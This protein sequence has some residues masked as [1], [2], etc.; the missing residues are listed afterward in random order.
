VSSSITL[1][2]GAA[3]GIGRAVAIQ[4]AN[5]GE[6]VFGIDIDEFGLEE[7]SQRS[8]GKIEIFNCDISSPT[9]VKALFES[10]D[11]SPFVLERYVAAAGIGLYKK[12]DEMTH[13]E[14]EKVIKVNLLGVLEPARLAL[15]RMINGGSMVFI[16]SVMATHSLYES[17][18]YSS[19]KGAVVTAARTL[20]LE[21]GERGIR[22]N[23]VSPGTIDTPMLARDMS[24]MNRDEQ[25]EFISKVNAANALGRIG[26]AN[27]VANLVSFLLSPAASYVT[28]SDFKVDGGFTAVKKF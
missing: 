21:A 27:E 15:P 9:E 28:A 22:V 25:D 10:I 12:F 19:T 1:V 18:V 2:T 6:L 5:R 24:S 11:Q 8:G 3:A 4:Q 7:T 23:S 14:M 20:A 16:A 17:V 13:E 26:E